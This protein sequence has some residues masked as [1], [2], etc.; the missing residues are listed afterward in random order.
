MHAPAKITLKNQT[1]MSL[2]AR[3]TAIMKSR[4]V[5][6]QQSAR[7]S[8][9]TQRPASEK[10]RRLAALME[11]RTGYSGS[12]IHHHHHHAEQRSHAP[13]APPSKPSVLERL[14]QRRGGVIPHIAVA[15]RGGGVASSRIGM[16]VGT[17][18]QGTMRGGVH[19]TYQNNR[20]GSFTGGRFQQRGR[21]GG[22]GGSFNRGRGGQRGGG[23]GG[24]AAQTSNKPVSKDDL[25]QALDSYMSSKGS[26]GD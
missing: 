20:G 26:S 12:Q 10:N 11:K 14:G 2:N 24:G 5:H 1:K 15:S 8:T 16:R 4:P 17:I 13:P 19:K 23:R 25:D 7:S 22:R 6:Q 18:R 9:S 21:G 3:F